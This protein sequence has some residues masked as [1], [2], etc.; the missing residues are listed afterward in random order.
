MSLVLD[1]QFPQPDLLVVK[2]GDRDVKLIFESPVTF[3]VYQ[4]IRWYLE[5]YATQYATDVDD[6]RASRIEKRLPEWGT[7]LFQAVFASQ[8][9]QQLFHDFWD[10]NVAGRLLT[11]STDHPSILALPWELLCQPLGTYLFEDNSQSYIRRRL[12]SVNNQFAKAKPKPKPKLNLRLLFVISRPDNAGFI[13]PRL[14]SLAVMT[15]LEKEQVSQ[16][17]VEFLR[18]PTIDNLETRLKCK[19]QFSDRPPVDIIHFDGHGIFEP[20]SNHGYLLFEE[21]GNKTDKV[22][23]Q[24]LGDLLRDCQVSLMVLSACQSAA[25]GDEG[26]I[27]SVA[28]RLT[29]AGVPAVV[30]MTHTVLA[31]TTCQLF[32]VFYQH[33]VAGLGVGAAL[34]KARWHLYTHPD[35]GER[36]R[37]AEQIV[38]KLYDWFSPALYQVGEDLP[39]LIKDTP[40]LETV[41]KGRKDTVYKGRKDRESNSIAGGESHHNLL[42]LHEAG[43]WGRSRELW[44]IERDFVRGTRRITITGFGGQ[45]KTCLA[46]EAGRWLQKTGM[47]ETVCFVDYAGFQ[48]IDAVSFAVS[49]MGKLLNKTLIDA[50]AILHILQHQP[51]LL[52]L[53]NLESLDPEP[54]QELLDWSKQWSKAGDSRVLLTTRTADLNHVAYPVGKRQEHV[55][56]TLGGLGSEQCPEDA[57]NYFQKLIVIPPAPNVQLPE[58]RELVNLFEQV[59]FHPLS[60]RLLTQQLKEQ[61]ITIV[62]KTLERLIETGQEISDK[63]R[64]LVASLNLSL[65][66][67]NEEARKWLLRLGVFQGGAFES[68][69]L[70]ITGLGKTEQ[71]GQIDQLSQYLLAHQAGDSSIAIPKGLPFSEEY[72]KQLSQFNPKELTEFLA[73][74][75]QGELIQ[76]VDSSTWSSL[77][78]VLVR[79]GLI[80]MKRVPSVGVPYIKFHPILR[81]FLWRH[82]SAIEQAELLTLHRH[83]YFQLSGHLHYADYTNPDLARAFARQELPNLLKAVYDTLA[84]GENEAVNFVDNINLFLKYFGLNQ[85]RAN[86]VHQLN[87]KEWGE[88]GSLNW[89][90]ARHQAGM[91]YY[92]LGQFVCAVEEFE[93]ILIGL[94]ETPTTERCGTLSRL[95]DCWRLLDQAD[96]AVELH[97]QALVEL[98]TLQENDSR[99]RQKVHSQRLEASIKCS[100]ADSLTDLGK[101]KEASTLYEMV[102]AIDKTLGD[103]KATATH[104]G[105]LCTSLLMQGKF[106]EAKTCYQTVQI[107]FQRLGETDSEAVAWHQLGELYVRERNW[108]AAE[109][110][111]R[112]AAQLDVSHGDISGAAQTWTSLGVINLNTGNSEVA[113]AWFRKALE[114]REILPGQGAIVLRN[115][116]FVLQDQHNLQRESERLAEAQQLAETALAINHTQ[117]PDVSEIWKTYE[118]LALIVKKKGDSAQA[119]IYRQ[120]AQRTKAKDRGLNKI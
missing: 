103:E 115:L 77:R 56:L 62:G 26:E 71:Q 94:G 12:V 5:V 80:Q 91:L 84:L 76:G 89:Y 53:D 65:K 63:D 85:E 118:L 64:S 87:K 88:L 11:I 68:L 30:A 93:Q 97:R 27:G 116:A 96:K 2:L 99:M 55:Y 35:R 79:S 20:H 112:K 60:I 31:E 82:L 110:A 39:L 9:A 15:A 69:L 104:Q 48:S 22:S 111:Y 33:L 66:Q 32:G 114:H 61:P 14:D 17:E 41:Y 28:A 50:T 92:D 7:Q 29:D 101:H 51:T 1:L 83:Y 44:A 102:L 36:Q 49:T 74:L 18:P 16:V 6:Q 43:F 58:R 40:S 34:N 3:G 70:F 107:D 100:L 105:Q 47:F 59:D 67:L 117:D 81:S 46:V 95:G 98:A 19:G 90:L 23:A 108:E 8:A 52:I 37:G 54:L 120:Q 78:Q 109:Q 106:V 72:V 4:E 57:L 38:L 75:P 24:R 119:K 113:E 42:S 13:D 73:Q 25:E 45:G 10:S 21:H 86:L